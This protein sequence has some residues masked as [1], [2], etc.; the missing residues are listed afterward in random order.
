MSGSSTVKVVQ[1]VLNGQITIPQEILSA[2][3]IADCS[4][5]QVGIDGDKIV[6]SKLEL[7]TDRDVRIYSDEEIAEF[8]E[9]DKLSPEL[10]EWARTRL[11]EKPV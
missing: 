2:L 8:L 9:A 6:I 7:E 5:V 4:L 1:P 10:A 11:G 3:S